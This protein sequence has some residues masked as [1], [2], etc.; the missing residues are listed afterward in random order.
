MRFIIPIPCGFLCG[1][2]IGRFLEIVS[3]VRTTKLVRKS[4]SDADQTPKLFVRRNP[5]K[6]FRRKPG[7]RRKTLVDEIQLADKQDQYFVTGFL[8]LAQSAHLFLHSRDSPHTP[9]DGTA[10]IFS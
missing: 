8:V 1:A 7:F 9:T 10:R 3:K 5:R 4:K 6:K 2:E